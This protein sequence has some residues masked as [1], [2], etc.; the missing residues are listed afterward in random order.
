MMIHTGIFRCFLRGKAARSAF[1]LIELLVVIAIISLLVSILI[2]SLTKARELARRSLCANNLHNI[3][4][5][6]Q[7]YA[8]D[9]NGWYPPRFKRSLSDV[10][11]NYNELVNTW[12]YISDLCDAKPWGKPM[13]SSFGMRGNGTGFERYVGDMDFNHRPEDLGVLYCPNIP[14]EDWPHP[15]T[16]DKDYRIGQQDDSYILLPYQMMVGCIAKTRST[17]RPLV[18]LVATCAEDP[19]DTLMLSDVV[20]LDDSRSFTF[21]PGTTSAMF[22]SNHPAG[23][24]V[25]Y[26]GSMRTTG[27]NVLRHDGAVTWTNLD[28]FTGVHRAGSTRDYYYL[29]PET[30]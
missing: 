2:P 16:T 25:N 9:Y 4:I 27:G 19:S 13:G 3:H 28:E 8:N 29:F 6:L 21:A 10:G 5:C 1:T 11:G 12:G 30:P 23:S 17:A 18:G 20:A 14:V 22:F 26:E 15:P 7:Y 24:L